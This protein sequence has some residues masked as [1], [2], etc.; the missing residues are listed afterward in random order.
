MTDATDD[1]AEF[2]VMKRAAAAEMGRD[3]TLNQRALDVSVEADRYSYSYQWT[4]LGLPIIQM[5]P[6]IVAT[7]EIIWDCRPQLIIET[8]V[9]RGGSAILSSSILELIGEGRV[10]AVDID[11]R[12]HN[13]AAIEEH[14]MARRIDLIQGSSVDPAVVAQVAERAAEVDRVMVILDSNHTH[15]HVLAELEAYAPLVS[16]GQFLIVADTAIE[17]IPVQDHRP[18]PWAPGNSPASALADYVARFP[19]FEADEHINAKLLM[20]SSPGGYLRCVGP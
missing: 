3:V 7:Q 20:T 18:R 19:R 12:A 5:P 2:D 10:V 11:I 4:W 13:R 9:A 16:P 17:H 8:G 15:E 6:D 1:R 14:P